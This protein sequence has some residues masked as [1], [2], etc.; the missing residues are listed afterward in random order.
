MKVYQKGTEM[1]TNAW[2]KFVMI[3]E[4]LADANISR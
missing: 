2:L 3:E 1:H 4:Q